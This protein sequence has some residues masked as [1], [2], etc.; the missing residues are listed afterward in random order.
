MSELP[1]VHVV[2]LAQGALAPELVHAAEV[3][4]GEKLP[5]QPVTLDWQ[6][7]FEQAATKTR[8][9]LA[10]LEDGA[11]ILV[12]TDMQGGTPHNV[13]SRLARA[14][15]VEVVSGVNLPMLVRLG[16]HGIAGKSVSVLARWIAGKGRSSIRRSEPP[17]ADAEPT[18]Q[19]DAD[20]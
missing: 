3:V 19:G 17:T 12:L 4:V 18:A 1:L 16:C 2:I 20:G 11:G 6:D 5:L 8:A 10:P 14:G 13:A 7:S 9:A 15:E